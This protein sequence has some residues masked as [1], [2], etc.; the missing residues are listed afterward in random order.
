MNYPPDVIGLSKAHRRPEPD[1][2]FRS[3]DLRAAYPVECSG[4][5][6]VVSDE[7]IDILYVDQD[8]ALPCRKPGCDAVAI[9]RISKRRGDANLS[10]QM[11]KMHICCPNR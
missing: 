9:D 11:S 7:Q 8:R 1:V 2:F 6:E 5:G 10:Q 4:P 3:I